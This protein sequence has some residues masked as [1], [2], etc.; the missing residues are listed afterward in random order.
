MRM[1]SADLADFPEGGKQREIIAGELYVSAR[2]HWYHQVACARFGGFLDAW[3]DESRSGQAAIA[4]GLI[5]DESND[6]APDVVWA[7]RERL[8]AILEEGKLYAAPELVIEILSPGRKNTARDRDTKLRLYARRGVDE[9]WIADW[10]RH[11]VEVYRREG[12]TL[13]LIATFG[14]GDTLTTPL[15][16]AFALPIAR[17]Y[18]GFPFA[19]ALADESK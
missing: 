19:D 4:P 5:F 2:P 9:Y 1:T 18:A 6:V 17:L 7:S 13:V 16:P 11:A 12:M 3:N 8:A 10:P 14:P 15:L